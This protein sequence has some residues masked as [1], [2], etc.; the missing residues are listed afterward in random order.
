MILMIWVNSI[1]VKAMEKYQIAMFLVW[2]WDYNSF[3]SELCYG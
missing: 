1:L 3:S 2:F